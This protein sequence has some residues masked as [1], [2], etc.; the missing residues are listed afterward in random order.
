MSST[1][2]Q[3]EYWNAVAWSKT[4]TLPFDG[5]RFAALVS[6]DQRV[7]DYGC[8]YGRLSAELRSRGFRNV[9]GVDPARQMIERG[10]RERPDLDLRV[11]C[12]SGLDDEAGTFDAVLLFGVL[13]TI[14]TDDGQRA[15]VR[16]AN[17]LLRPGG[18]LYL[19]DFSLND[20][21]RNRERYEQF[22]GEFGTYGVFRHAEGVVLRHHDR[23]WI[24]SLVRDFET[25]GFFEINVITMNGNPAKA[26]QYLGRKTG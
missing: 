14:P 16:E 26:F 5:E 8:G 20:D 23:R 10:R 24:E 25:L 19:S 12:E 4:C 13:T 21:D 7:L 22:V 17:R 3:T 9:V 11:L 1:D 6:A 15:C 2:N 18:V